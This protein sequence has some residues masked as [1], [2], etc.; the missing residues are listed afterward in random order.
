MKVKTFAELP[1]TYRCS[2]C[3]REKPLVE[4]IV[5]RLRGRGV[6][7]LRSRCKACHNRR[8]RGHRR[9]WKT[10][11]LRRWR[12]N[13]PELN[14]SYWR[15][16]NTAR[17]AELSVMAEK[18]RQKHHAALL[19]QGR[20]RRRLGMRVPLAEA[21]RLCQKYGPC[22][23]T[24][25]GLSPKGL[26]ECERIRGRIRASGGRP[27]AIEI[28]LMVYEDGFFTRPKRQ[29][30]PYQAAAERLRAW[31]AARRAEARCN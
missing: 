29:K 19:I 5:V 18:W 31:Q 3:E 24:R 23:P 11:Y 6:I 2:N 20:F 9:E 28:R 12:S 13:H 15:Q 25:F 27:C 7:L 1:A 4:M 26:R 16:R 10:K 22:Y 21:E 17:R 30:I 14:E 8:E